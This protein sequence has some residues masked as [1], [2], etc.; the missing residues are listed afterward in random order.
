MTLVNHK[1]AILDV[2]DVVQKA[3]RPLKNKREA[4]E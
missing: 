4:L 1:M 3:F 2:D